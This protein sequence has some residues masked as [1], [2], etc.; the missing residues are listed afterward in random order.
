MAPPTNRPFHY[1]DH[2][3][4]LEVLVLVPVLELVLVRELVAVLEPVD[5][6]VPVLEPV[7][8]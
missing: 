4:H 6:L 1:T 5:V 3:T 8:V 7:L 2:D